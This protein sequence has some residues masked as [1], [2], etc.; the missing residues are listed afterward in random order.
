M[1]MHHGDR[2]VVHILQAQPKVVVKEEEEYVYD[3]GC[4]PLYTGLESGDRTGV[5]A[6]VEEN[7]NPVVGVPKISNTNMAGRQ[8]LYEKRILEV[9]EDLPSDYDTDTEVE[10]DEDGEFVDDP[11]Q[12]RSICLTS[13]PY[14][15]ADSENGAAQCKGGVATNQEHPDQEGLSTSTNGQELP[16]FSE[17]ELPSTSTQGYQARRRWRKKSEAAQ[18][19]QFQPY[20]KNESVYFSA[21]HAFLEF[22]DE[23]IISS[24]VYQSNLYSV[25]KGKAIAL[26][27][28][29]L[30]VFFGINIMMSYH[31]LP[32]L[33]NF[34]ATGEDLGVRPIQEA[35]SRDRFCKILSNLHLNDNQKMDPMKKDKLYKLRP[36]VESL[37]KKFQNIRSPGEHISVDESMIRF[38][39]RSSLKQYNPIKPIKKGYKVWCLADNAGYVFKFDIYTGKGENNDPNMRKEF[40]LGGEVV[41]RLTEHLHNKNHKLFF[42]NYFT[43]FSLLEV[44]QGLKIQ[45]CGTVRQT[46]KDFPILAG[47]K[48]LKRGQFDYR[49]TPNGLTV[50]KWMDK[51]AV[52]MASN[53]H[54]I[55]ATT[56]KRT[57]KDRKKA[58]V[59]CPQVVKDYNDNMGGVD[60]HDML[61]QLYGTNRK[62]MKWWH[63]IFWGLLDMCIVNAY[64]VYKESHGSL[65][66][67]D[68]RRDL[69][70]GLL[71]Y[72]KECSRGAPK[73]R[74]TDYTIPPSVRLSNT[75]I[76][77]PKFIGKKGRCEVCSKKG[78]ESR[79][80]SICSHCGIHLCCNATKNCFYEFHT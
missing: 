17:K 10:E 77:W 32:S 49:S 4:D 70:Q 37:N 48:K 58:I 15:T 13:E 72:S 43:S 47:D 26:T 62:S 40:G 66:L 78:V 59:P 23:E 34:W 19:V 41:L 20:S 71:T 36:L 22:F 21:L 74:K 18:N 30:H 76:H 8:R 53:Y 39:G 79:P 44:L 14:A 80:I 73:R 28:D 7:L 54:G 29:E 12:P 16:T 57:E 75:G 56:V 65:P 46:R 52:L 3:E 68:F 24:V 27:E 6:E 11:D 5:T 67:L 2:K 31:K 69:A 55:E 33:G 1:W 61:R 63:R 25:Q 51:K 38:K 9:L 45:A 60:K 64:V 35:M 50:Y 42:D